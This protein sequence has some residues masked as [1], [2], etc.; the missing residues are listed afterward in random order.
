MKL[1]KHDYTITAYNHN[2]MI[3]KSFIIKAI[4][5]D[6]F[7]ALKIIQILEPNEHWVEVDIEEND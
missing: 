5:V 6:E 1:K 2:K 4:R 7:Q 3:C